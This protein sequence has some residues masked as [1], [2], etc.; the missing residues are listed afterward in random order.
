VTGLAVPARDT[1]KEWIA[2]KAREFTIQAGAGA[3]ALGTVET[4]KLAVHRTR[5]N[6]S[7]TESFPSAHSAGAA[8]FSTLAFR[9]IESLS[10]SGSAQTGAR[11]GLGALTAATAWARVE[12]DV[13]YPSDVLAG[14]AIGRFFGAFVTE[15]FLGPDNPQHAS[16]LVEPSRKGTV[17]MI[18]IG[19]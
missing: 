17:A 8:L 7:D 6:G 11:I 19:F 2:V 12:A 10:W 16:V 3:A 14:I 15:A 9:N 13:H 5:P 4:L 1:D 18:C